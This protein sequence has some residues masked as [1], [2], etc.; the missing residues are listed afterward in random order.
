MMAA[1]DPR[2]VESG[3]A[4]RQ[5]GL[6]HRKRQPGGPGPHPAV[7]MLHGRSGDEDAMWIFA[8]TVPDE[9]LLAAPR[10]IKPDPR[11]GYAWHPRRP[12]EWPTLEQ[13]GEAVSAVAQFVRALPTLYDADPDRIYLMG[14][15]Q[16]AATAYATAMLHRGLVQG[17]AGLVGFVPV[18]C[19]TAVETRQLQGLPIL[20]V[21]GKQDPLIPYER[22]QGCAETLR[23]AGADLT[24]H[25]YESGHRL[26]AEAMRDLKTWWQAQV[27]AGSK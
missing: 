1:N 23:E 13:F 16:G 15:S 17:I 7:V 3:P 11:G 27:G 4:V 20:M 26:N 5:S 21:V 12:D 25:S 19:G 24:Y 14:F 22:S 10:A 9:W 6:I 18:A 8:R 2:L